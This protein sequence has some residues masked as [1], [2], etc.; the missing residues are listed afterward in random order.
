MEKYK[1]GAAS[2]VRLFHKR[3]G[4]VQE[5]DL[6]PTFKLPGS[7]MDAER[8]L[9]VVIVDVRR[10]YPLKLPP[11]KNPSVVPAD[12]TSIPPNVNTASAVPRR[13]NAQ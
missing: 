11:M 8:S 4:S 2:R 13:R 12:D 1:A 6:H 5:N 3:R 7:W 9:V 10:R